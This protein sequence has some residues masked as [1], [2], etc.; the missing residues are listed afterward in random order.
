MTEENYGNK[1]YK[2]KLRKNIF[3]L[4]NVKSYVNQLLD[5]DEMKML[6]FIDVISEDKL[7][8]TYVI[9]TQKKY[10]LIL[11]LF[12]KE[13]FVEIWKEL[14]EIGPQI[15]YIITIGGD[16]KIDGVGRGK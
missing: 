1:L 2:L 11:P 8:E 5:I 6:E 12:D 4:L 13:T 16:T 3:R 7:Y 14:S 15:G 10:G 9:L